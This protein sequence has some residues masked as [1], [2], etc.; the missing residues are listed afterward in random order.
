[1]VIIPLI[2][3][4]IILGLASTN[5]VNQMKRLGIRFTLFVL[6]TTVLASLLGI[7]LTTV[8]SPGRGLSLKLPASSASTTPVTEMF[9]FGP[10]TIL[11]ILPLNPLS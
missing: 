11:N 10:D 1:M 5:D 9:S 8:I 4:S 3:S 2:F 6:S 7:F